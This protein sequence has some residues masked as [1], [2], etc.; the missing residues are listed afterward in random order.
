MQSS[1]PAVQKLLATK[2]VDLAFCVDCTGSM[3]QWLEFVKAKVVNIATAVKKDPRVMRVRMAFVGYRD[4]VYPSDQR[5]VLIPFMDN[6]DQFA[7]SIRDVPA[8]YCNGND[9]PEDLLGGLNQ[10]ITKLEWQ[11]KCRIVIVITD[12]PCHGGKEY[13]DLEENP[14]NAS[15]RDPLRPD[16]L[17]RAIGDR[18]SIDL[19]F[20]RIKSDTDRMV[21]KFQK[22]YDN[23]AKRKQLEIVQLTDQVDDFMAKIVKTVT[24]SVNR[25]NR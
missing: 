17:L 5:Y 25:A 7:N 3:K 15:Y 2:T 6:P 10:C 24:Q 19:T 22:F 4:Y 9:E 18:F 23:P 21:A 20:C 16:T 1:N 13:H 11:S 8:L 14:N 12:A